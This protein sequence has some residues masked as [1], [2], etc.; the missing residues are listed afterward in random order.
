MNLKLEFEIDKLTNGTNYKA[1][2]EKKLAI[3]VT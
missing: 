3:S 1:V 2:T